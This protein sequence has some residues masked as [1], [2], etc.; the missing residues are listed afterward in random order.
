MVFE[1][2]RLFHTFWLMWVNIECKQIM[3]TNS[4]VGIVKIL[5]EDYT[6]RGKTTGFFY[7]DIS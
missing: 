4:F 7:P 5:T 2:P 3:V 6:N 1:A